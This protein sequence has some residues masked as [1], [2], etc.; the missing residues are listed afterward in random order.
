MELHDDFALKNPDPSKR[1]E[2]DFSQ[3][4]A[5][6]NNLFPVKEHSGEPRVSIVDDV[7]NLNADDSNISFNTTGWSVAPII[8]PEDGWYYIE[9][10]NR[11]LH[12]DYNTYNYWDYRTS[13]DGTWYHILEN[14]PLYG[15]AYGPD[16]YDWRKEAVHSYQYLTAGSRIDFRTC[17]HHSTYSSIEWEGKDFR[18]YQLSST[19]EVTDDSASNDEGVY[20]EI[21]DSQMSSLQMTADASVV[22]RNSTISNSSSNG[23]LMTGSASTLDIQHSIISGHE[24]DGIQVTS[25]EGNLSIENAI[26]AE[27]SGD[28]IDSFIDKFIKSRHSFTEHWKWYTRLLPFTDE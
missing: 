23:I 6:F 3:N 20:L 9:I 10:D 21:D 27:N 26:I 15:T 19:P 28:G 2:M 18:I 11:L 14:N 24:E 8:V 17:Y 4:E 1:G 7:L 22:I 25:L 5:D 12:A 16:N 13:S